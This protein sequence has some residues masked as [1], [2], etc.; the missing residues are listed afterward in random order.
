M[1]AKE[2][3]ALAEAGLASPKGGDGEEAETEEEEEEGDDTKG[4]GRT[5]FSLR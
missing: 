5:H 4:K 1:K 2:M 3:E